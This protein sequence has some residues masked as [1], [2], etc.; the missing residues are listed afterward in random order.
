VL[1]LLPTRRGQEEEE[2]EQERGQEGPAHR[3]ELVIL[4]DYASADA[5]AYTSTD[6]SAYTSTDAN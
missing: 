5:S 3:Q 6:A 2:A 1:P 4:G